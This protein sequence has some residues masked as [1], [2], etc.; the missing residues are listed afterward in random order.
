VA[1]EL[2]HAAAVPQIQCDRTQL[3]IV[4]HNLL[5]N[6]LDSVLSRPPAERAIA[7][8]LEVVD[9]A[10]VFKV[11]DSG[12]GI[13]VA[14]GEQLFEPFVTS[15]PDGMGLG[16]AISRSLIRSR[17]GELSFSLSSALGG[18]AFTI[19]L[20]IELPADLVQS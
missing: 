8:S 9:S 3:E 1:F 20:P 10:I 18:A 4:L 19:R 6:A 7:L 15:K 5:S 17:G 13:P 14:I 11:E 12:R 16:L 2:E